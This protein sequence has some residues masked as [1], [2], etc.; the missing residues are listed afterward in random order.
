MDPLTVLNDVTPIG[1]IGLLAYAI[2]LLVRQKKT[3]NSIAHN[4]LSGLP[5]MHATLDK[6]A[7]GIERIEHSLATVATQVTYLTAKVNGG[8]FPP[9]VK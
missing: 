7:G 1:A 9:I 4:H 6:I 5:D 2:V 3:V 8:P